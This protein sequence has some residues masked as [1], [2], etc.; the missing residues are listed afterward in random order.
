[1]ELAQ[2]TPFTTEVCEAPDGILL[3]N[4]SFSLSQSPARYFFLAAR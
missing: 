4:I 1:M 2:D 3:S